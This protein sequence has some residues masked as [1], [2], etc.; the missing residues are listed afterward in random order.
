MLIAVD[1]YLHPVFWAQSSPFY[2]LT[3]MLDSRSDVR[4]MKEHKVGLRLGGMAKCGHQTY[5]GQE[6]T[7]NL[8]I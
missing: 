1:T 6:S 3:Y 8:V 4:K 2:H 5:L 7:S